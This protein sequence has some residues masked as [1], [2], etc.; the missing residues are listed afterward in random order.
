[1]SVSY[2]DEGSRTGSTLIFIHGFPFNKHSWEDQLDLMKDDY[3][4]IAYD[5][6]GHGDSSSGI[7]KFTVQQFVTDLF[8]FMD[9]LRIEKA[10][11]CGLSMGG[12]IALQAIKQHPDRITGLI[13]C[14]TQCAADTEEVKKKRADTIQAVQANGVKQYAKD[15]VEKL[16][17]K[18]SLA[19]KQEVVSVIER[20]ILLTPIE[21]ISNTLMALAGR[22][23]TCSS[24]R[25][26]GVPVLIIVGAEDQITSPEAAQKMHELIPH[27]ELEILEKAGH[28]SNLEASENFNLHLRVFLKSTQPSDLFK[29]LA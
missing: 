2:F 7:R 19:D 14:D 11:L 4:V 22:S 27:S 24:L 9:A 15:S 5:V 12:Y 8:L 1:L 3:R 21:T 18:T 26:I 17:S 10:F 28:M 13:L 20:T 6:R 25:H 23:E 16:F 29:T